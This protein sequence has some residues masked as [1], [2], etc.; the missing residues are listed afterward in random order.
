MNGILLNLKN[1]TAV[2]AMFD[3]QAI[4][5]EQQ[6]AYIVTYCRANPSALVVTAIMDLASKHLMRPSR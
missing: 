4:S 5:A 1:V 6:W 3:L 2:A